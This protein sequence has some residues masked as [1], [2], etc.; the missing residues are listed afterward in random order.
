MPKYF[1][2]FH[3]IFL[4]NENIRWL[5]EFLLYY[6]KLGFEQFYLYNNDGSVGRNGSTS[7][8]NKYGFSITSADDAHN[9]ILFNE[10]VT[11]YKTY[12]TLIEWQ[13]KDKDGNICY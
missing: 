7:H 10:I 8:I 13:P 2:S 12:I 6:I 1:L 5:E 9:V 11:K 3:T 4:I